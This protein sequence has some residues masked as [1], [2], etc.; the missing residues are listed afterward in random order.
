M[1]I[2]YRFQA[3]SGYFGLKNWLLIEVMFM[4]HSLMTNETTCIFRKSSK[5]AYLA[6][7]FSGKWIWVQVYL[8]AAMNSIQVLSDILC[9]WDIYY[10]RNVNTVHLK[11]LIIYD[12]FESSHWLCVILDL[13]YFINYWAF[14]VSFWKYRKRLQKRKTDDKI[15][16]I[17]LEGILN[18]PFKFGFW[19]AIEIRLP[20]WLR[21]PLPKHHF[22]TPFRKTKFNWER[23]QYDW[24]QA[25]FKLFLTYYKNVAHIAMLVTIFGCNKVNL[26]VMIQLRYFHLEVRSWV[27]NQGQF[28]LQGLRM[29]HHHNLDRLLFD[30]QEREPW[31]CLA[32]PQEFLELL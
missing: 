13:E 3:R 8:S 12:S 32:F 30:H 26:K 6:C 15:R 16:R 2:L 18:W 25:R 22:E 4:M 28:H 27:Q 10:L 14:L 23:T 5:C 24:Y 29:I 11:W 31:H 21:A 1:V 9:R 17:D 7:T 19:L 20:D